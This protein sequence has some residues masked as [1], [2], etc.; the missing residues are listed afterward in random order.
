MKAQKRRGGDVMYV[1]RYFALLLLLFSTPAFARNCEGSPQAL[2]TVTIGETVTI[3]Q[4]MKI[5]AICSRQLRLGG[6]RAA[7]WSILALE[8]VE[9]PKNVFKVAST[10]YSFAFSA[11]KVGSYQIRYRYKLRSNHNSNE[12]YVNYIMNV[13]VVPAAW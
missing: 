5:N 7:P 4:K 12:G 11:S 8:F 3:Q 6:K 1:F 2:R 9:Y 13:E 10:A